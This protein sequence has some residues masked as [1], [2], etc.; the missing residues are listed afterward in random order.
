MTF[1]IKLKYT[2]PLFPNT[3]TINNLYKEDI[4]K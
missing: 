1:I 3:N 2:Y 4:H